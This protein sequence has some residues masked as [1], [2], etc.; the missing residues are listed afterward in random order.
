MK[1]K[2]HVKDIQVNIA[3]EV[4]V[5][6]RKN[7][8]LLT[9][10]VKG[11]EKHLENHANSENEETLK[12]VKSFKRESTDVL[13]VFLND[14]KEELD[15]VI[16]IDDLNNHIYEHVKNGERISSYDI[17]RESYY[18]AWQDQCDEDDGEKDFDKYL[19][20]FDTV[21]EHGNELMVDYIEDDVYN[22]DWE[23]VE[24]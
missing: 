14:L 11:I 17:G 24:D 16:V 22:D 23:L 3:S 8:S 20:D 21:V 19:P 1:Y 12:L 6:V 5:E 13:D 15:F 7:T 4:I 18:R 9:V 2:V 10:V